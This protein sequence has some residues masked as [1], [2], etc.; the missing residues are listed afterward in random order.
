MVTCH[1]EG[2]LGTHIHDPNGWHIEL[3]DG[4][5]VLFMVPYPAVIILHCKVWIPATI[6]IQR[7]TTGSDRIIRKGKRDGTCIR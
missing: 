1:K 7:D 6:L 4:F 3:V 2:A 5:V